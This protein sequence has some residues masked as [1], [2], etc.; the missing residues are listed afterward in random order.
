MYL[1]YNRESTDFWLGKEREDPKQTELVNAQRRELDPEKRKQIFQEFVK[2]DIGQ[3]Y[4]LP[5]HFPQDWKPYAIG[6]P[7][8]GSW[9]W[10]QMYI[11]QYPTGAGQVLSQLWKKA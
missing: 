7:T 5:Y 2:Y 3:M 10:W 4:Y 8:V 6:R 1:M 9:G 11:E